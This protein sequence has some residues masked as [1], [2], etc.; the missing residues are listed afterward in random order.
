MKEK[1]WFGYIGASSVLAVIVVLVSIWARADWYYYLVTPVYLYQQLLLTGLV[2]REGWQIGY[3]AISLCALLGG[4]LLRR[5]GELRWSSVLIFLPLIIPTCHQLIMLWLT[6]RSME[7]SEFWAMI[8]YIASCVL[9]CILLCIY[10]FGI[11]KEK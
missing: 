4:I 7:W 6:Y 3:A 10:R 2:L 1:L 5:K 9:N 8:P 11:Y